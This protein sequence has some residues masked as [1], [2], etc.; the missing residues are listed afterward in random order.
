MRDPREDLNNLNALG[1]LGKAKPEQLKDMVLQAETFLEQIQELI[2]YLPQLA[3]EIRRER[4][5]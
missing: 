3:D 1:W 5:Q 2:G 4:G